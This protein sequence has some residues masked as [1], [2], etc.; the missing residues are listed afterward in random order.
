[1]AA[2]KPAAEP[3]LLPPPAVLEKR[4]RDVRSA[5]TRSLMGRLAADPPQSIIIEGGTTEERLAHALYWAC[6][7]NCEN[8]AS[9]GCLKC[10]ACRR[11]L[12]NRHLDLFFF[13]GRGQSI[14]IDELRSIRAVLGEEPRY[15]RR[16]LVLLFEAQA[17]GVEAANSQLKLLED[18]RPGT[19]FAMTAPQRARLLPTLVS[20]SWVVTLPWPS[21]PTP[22]EEAESEADAALREAFVSFLRT[23]TGLFARTAG[24]G[25]VDKNVAVRLVGW[26]QKQLA[27]VLKGEGAAS[28]LGGLGRDGARAAGEML[29]HCL[30]SLDA[31]VTPGV[32]VEWLAT[33]LYLRLREKNRGA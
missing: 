2:P 12:E 13:D 17:M 5:R 26:L 27:A 11:L 6:L 21:G 30:E 4:L 18:P 19:C 3:S 31:S 9:P 23:G 16:R 14:K 8:A 24:K 32:C 28:P 22:G 33:S 20:R 29:A 7:L 25:G 1:M 10:D 15:G